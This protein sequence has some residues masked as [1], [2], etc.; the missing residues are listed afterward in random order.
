MQSNIQF[1]KPYEAKENPTSC[2]GGVDAHARIGELL[3]G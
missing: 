3:A 2:K 1:S